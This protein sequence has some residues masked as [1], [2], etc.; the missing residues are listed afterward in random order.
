MATRYGKDPIFDSRVFSFFALGPV[1]LQLMGFRLERLTP[2][3]RSR[4]WNFEVL[5]GVPSRW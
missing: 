4:S 5:A 1:G 3:T 2:N